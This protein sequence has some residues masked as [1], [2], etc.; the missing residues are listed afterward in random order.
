[1][2]FSSDNR[3]IGRRSVLVGGAAVLAGAGFVEPARAVAAG[4]SAGRRA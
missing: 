3:G 4:P 2:A 1:M